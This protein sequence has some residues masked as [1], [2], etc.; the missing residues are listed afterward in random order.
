MESVSYN[1]YYR[2]LRAYVFLDAPP[3]RQ[4]VLVPRGEQWWSEYVLS[5]EM[6][7]SERWDAGKLK[8]IRKYES[9]HDHS[10]SLVVTADHREYQ[11]HTRPP[12]AHLAT[13]VVHYRVFTRR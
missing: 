10:R 4:P 6:S 9:L 13:V 8:Q 3:E 5:T 7:R 12:I 2:Y 11:L 1:N